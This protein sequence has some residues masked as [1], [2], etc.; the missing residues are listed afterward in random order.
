VISKRQRSFE[1]PTGVESS[2]DMACCGAAVYLL[3]IHYMSSGVGSFSAIGERSFGDRG[4]SGCW[5]A[6]SAEISSS[7]PRAQYWKRLT[8][9]PLSAASEGE[10]SVRT[11][12]R[13]HLPDAGAP[14][15]VILGWLRP[16]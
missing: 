4:F 7:G 8:H 11:H 3:Y 12:P 9:D 13:A 1:A 14:P 15:S 5:M 10:T 6:V 2:N 16:W